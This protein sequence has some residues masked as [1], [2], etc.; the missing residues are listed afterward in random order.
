MTYSDVFQQS[1]SEIRLYPSSIA[2]DKTDDYVNIQAE[3]YR[4]RLAGHKLAHTVLAA[5]SL[6]LMIWHSMTSWSFAASTRTRLA[7][8]SGSWGDDRTGRYEQTSR[9]G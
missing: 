9:S 5:A 6:A 2:L 8:S 7:P 3:Q 4:R 1:L